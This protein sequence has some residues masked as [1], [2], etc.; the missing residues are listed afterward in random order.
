MKKIITSL[1]LLISIT[2]LNAQNKNQLYTDY[3]ENQHLCGPID[4]EFL[5][6]DSLTASWYSESQAEFELSSKAHDWKGNL[7]NTQVDIYLGTWCGDS[8]NWVPK[9]VKLWEE[10]GLS[11]EQLNFIGLY[12][13]DER[14]K[15]GPNGE[16][17]GKNIHRVPT[18][19]F[20]QN[21][22]EYARIVEYPQSDLETDLA[23]I[24]LGYPPLPSY[25]GAN[26]LME[27]LNEQGEE[28]LREN[29]KEIV[30]KVYR[31]QAGSS[32]LNT[33][34][35]V[36]L[37]AGELDKSISVFY[38]NTLCHRYV[39]N[40]HD[41]Y[42]EALEAKGFHEQALEKYRLVLKMDEENEHAKERIAVLEGKLEGQ[43][44]PVE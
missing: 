2:S 28:Y 33:L 44:N 30:N 17:K 21:G 40:V 22:E 12:N 31:L 24:A 10:L 36:Y 29:Y 43:A 25:K 15:Q 5:E 34:G 13:D 41:S 19:I 38:I 9:F 16:E 18:F 7:E 23:Q 14:Y 20:N 3:K 26:Y 39:P 4:L 6:S 42:A 27:I 8:K 11:W 35:Y 1:L 32:E 37:R